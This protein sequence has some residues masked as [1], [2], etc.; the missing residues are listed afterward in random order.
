MV[1]CVLR[2]F[3]LRPRSQEFKELELVVLRHELAILRRQM[4]RAQLTVTDRPGHAAPLLRWHRRL[5]SAP[6]TSWPRIA[7]RRTGGALCPE[8]ALY[9]RRYSSSA[10]LARNS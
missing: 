6:S 3:L 5:Q 2:L 9:S 8:A 4:G 10:G 7:G 1:R